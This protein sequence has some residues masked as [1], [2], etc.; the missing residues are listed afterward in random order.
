MS[1]VAAAGIDPA[2]QCQPSLGTPAS[3]LRQP[4][5]D[6][7]PSTALCGC[8]G[9]SHGL[10]LFHLTSR[11]NLSHHFKFQ[12]SVMV[13]SHSASTGAGEPPGTQVALASR[14]S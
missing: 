5:E 3:P 1:P 12:T 14:D 13:G 9:G 8:E 11:N 2:L 4:G 6:P 10:K 7:F